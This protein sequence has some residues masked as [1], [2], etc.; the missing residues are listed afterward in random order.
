MET[1][2]LVEIG[3]LADELADHLLGISHALSRRGE[4]VVDVGSGEELNEQV[5]K[6]T[7]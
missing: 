2:E 6:G 4:E 3:G 1:E 7:V 5:L